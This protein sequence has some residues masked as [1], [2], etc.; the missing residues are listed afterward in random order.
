[1]RADVEPVPW[2]HNLVAGPAPERRQVRAFHFGRRPRLQ[3]REARRKQMRIIS[4]VVPVSVALMLATAC[5]RQPAFRPVASVKQI[6][7]GS[8]HPASEVVFEAVGTIVS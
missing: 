7:E 8:V 3:C 1:M 2:Q 4:L 5:R 6:M